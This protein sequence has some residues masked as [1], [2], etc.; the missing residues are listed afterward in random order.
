M[1]QWIPGLIG[2]EVLSM[3]NVLSKT[4]AKDVLLCGF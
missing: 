3:V 2:S 4:V 1:M